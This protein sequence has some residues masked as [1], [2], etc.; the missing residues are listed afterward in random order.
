MIKDTF[1]LKTRGEHFLTIDDIKFD[2]SNGFTYQQAYM[3]LKDFVCSGLLNVNDQFEGKQM[4]SKEK[5]S[6]VA[7]N[8]LTKEWLSKIDPRLP[9]HIKDTRG[10][11]FT[12][13][14]VQVLS[15]F[16]TNPT[17]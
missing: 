1:G 14:I 12:P 4:T 7:K 16:K 3:Q 8:F 11:L 6:P 10:H 5:L 13:T 17:V 15:D 9:G 2:F